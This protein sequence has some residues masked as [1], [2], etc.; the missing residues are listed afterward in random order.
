MPRIGYFRLQQDCWNG[1]EQPLA[2][3]LMCLNSGGV[4]GTGTLVKFIRVAGRNLR[5]FL[6]LGLFLI[7]L[8]IKAHLVSGKCQLVSLSE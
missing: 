6:V 5:L 2:Y 4:R 8:S 1:S 7:A 3:E